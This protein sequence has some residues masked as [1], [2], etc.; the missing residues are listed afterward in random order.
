M[1]RCF[2]DTPV[3]EITPADAIFWV[4]K[5]IVVVAVYSL[6]VI[7]PL[8]AIGAVALSV[9]AAIADPAGALTLAGI[10]LFA[11][12]AIVLSRKVEAYFDRLN[13]R[14]TERK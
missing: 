4:L 3:A 13:K 10:A 6:Y 2:L 7:V 8:A 1:N 14:I 5:P 12:P 9:G 11:W